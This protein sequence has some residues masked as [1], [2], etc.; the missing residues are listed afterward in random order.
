[1]H[2]TLEDFIQAVR[3]ANVRVSVAE[4][5]EAFETVRLVGYSDRQVLRDALSVTVAKT[6][7]EKRRF[8]QAFDRFF[9]SDV[10]GDAPPG[11]AAPTEDAGPEDLE[12]DLGLDAERENEIVEM[13]LKGDRVGLTSAMR[14]AAREVGLSNIAFFSQ[15]GIY[16]QRIVRRMGLDALDRRI[17]EL[18]RAGAGDSEQAGRLRQARGYFIDQVKAF[19][20]EQMQLYTGANT[21]QL[22]EESLK[23]RRLSKIDPDEFER[24]KAITQEMAR[25][26]ANVHAKR[27]K[28]ALR[29]QIDIRRTLRKNM[30]YDGELFDLHWKRTRIDRPRVVAICDVSRSVADYS[31]FL[32][33][34]L[35]AMSTAM[36]RIRTFTFCSDVVEVSGIMENNP[37]EEA[38]LQAQAAAPI[39]STD[40]G[41]VF[42]TLEK[43]YLNAFTN[44]TTVIV[45]GDARNNELP[46][47]TGLLKM[48]QQRS[49]NIIWLNP[50]PP[51]AWGTGDSEME[52]YRP[53]CQMVREAGT[54]NHLQSAMDEM[55]RLTMRAA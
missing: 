30:G 25:R 8:E 46:P 1:M 34:F 3:G 36:S 10:F 18:E 9:T 52:N 4:T 24:M 17:S 15:K 49:R 47:E 2:R 38:L 29:G 41:Q 45:L 42:R 33:L 37:V 11:G 50:E 55:L 53:F 20:G 40:Y 21:Q 31:R 12:P 26:L 48:I 14:E 5:L 13:L 6:P 16:L 32:L 54:I 7:E 22:R 35:Y 39:G 19:V 23:D 43:D 44:K 27:A 28:R 51:V